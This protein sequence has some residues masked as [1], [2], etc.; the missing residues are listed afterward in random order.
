[1]LENIQ[2]IVNRISVLAAV[3]CAVLSAAPLYA[4]TAQEL[5]ARPTEDTP[6]STAP[7][8]S[9]PFARWKTGKSV[10]NIQR[11]LA[12]MGL[13]LGPINGHLSD[14]TRAAIRIYQKGAGLKVDG[15]ITRDLWDLLNNTVKVR[16]LLK[17]LEKARKTGRDAAR[18]ALLSHPATR[19]LVDIP[20]T[21]RADPTRNPDACFETPTVRCLLVEAS[22][23]VKAVFRPE[24]RDWALGEIL[25]AEARAGLTQNAMRTVRRIRDPRLI[26]VALRDI[27]EAE[28]AAGSPAEAWA[29]VEIIPD[30]EKRADA[31]AAIAEIQVRRKEPVEARKTTSRLLALLE[32]LPSALKRISLRSRAAVII[33]GAGDKNAAARQMTVAEWE[34]R[35]K[36][37]GQEQGMALRYVASA[38]AEMLHASKALALLEDISSPSERTSVLVSTAEAQ[39]RAGDAAAALAT[40]DNIVTVR[41]KAAVLG[42]IAQTQAARGERA[43][44]E[45]TIELALGAVENIKSPYARSFA[46]TRIALAMSSLTET[47]NKADASKAAFT[48]AKAAE[49]ATKIDD[50]RLRAH[51][52]WAITA[53]QQAA[54]DV[55]GAKQTEAA[56]EAATKAIVSRLSRVWMFGDIALTHARQGHRDRAEENF[57]RG[58]DIARSLENTWARSRALARLATVLVEVADPKPALMIGNPH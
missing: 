56:A 42:R 39:V 45:T 55:E 27:A 57:Q 30:R 48:Y 6:S 26:M 50:N 32:K 51:T 37:N 41:F 49:T 2:T 24:L 14:E 18:Q 22:E 52:L 33:A 46:V 1:M 8:T 7:E 13:Y 3:C 58:L 25:V 16:Q 21:E 35:D 17:R 10:E 28:A 38:L 47:G 53:A 34:A 4:A 12:D 36:L 44:A 29:A 11:A 15:K 40:A 9:S 54:N 43:D 23:S 19:D 5:A 31:L 20:N